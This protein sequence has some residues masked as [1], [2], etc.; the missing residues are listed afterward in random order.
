MIIQIPHI[1]SMIFN[2]QW[3]KT[4]IFLIETKRSMKPLEFLELRKLKL[5]KFN[6]T[7]ALKQ[8]KNKD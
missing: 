7:K 8:R 4:L 3:V 6:I 2:A 1:D 5:N